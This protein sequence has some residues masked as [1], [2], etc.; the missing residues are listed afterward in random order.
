MNGLSTAYKRRLDLISVGFARAYS[1]PA[2]IVQLLCLWMKCKPFL[3]VKQ[4]CTAPRFQL[5]LKLDSF[6]SKVLCT[7]NQKI[8]SYEVQYIP[9]NYPELQPDEFV[10]RHDQPIQCAWASDVFE[11]DFVSFVELSDGYGNGDDHVIKAIAKHEDVM[12]CESAWTVFEFGVVA[13]LRIV[14]GDTAQYEAYF[15]RYIRLISFN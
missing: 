14:E 12:L 3:L 1:L 13:F 15:E 2:G 11:T 7:L 5:E 6:S 4:I 10:K 8:D 9:Y